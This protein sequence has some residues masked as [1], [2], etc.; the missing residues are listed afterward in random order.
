MAGEKVKEMWEQSDAL[1][2]LIGTVNVDGKQYK[3]TKQHIFANMIGD[4]RRNDSNLLNRALTSWC[5]EVRLEL[6]ALPC[7]QRLCES[8]QPSS[9]VRRKKNP[10]ASSG[11]EL[12]LAVWFIDKIGSYQRA[13]EVIQAAAGA[14]ERIQK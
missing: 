6:V 13:L 7:F 3:V 14:M 5:D 4:L 12:R 10:L 11:D 2:H 8:V 9:T 1:A